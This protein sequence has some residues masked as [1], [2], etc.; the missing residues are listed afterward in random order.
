[1]LV[2]ITTEDQ[3]VGQLHKDTVKDLLELQAEVPVVGQAEDLAE[4]LQQTKDHCSIAIFATSKD[5]V[6]EN[7]EDIKETGQE[8]MSVLNVEDDTPLSV[9]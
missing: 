8:L 9:G 4:V 3:A 2:R 6:S 1:M 7:A 5:M